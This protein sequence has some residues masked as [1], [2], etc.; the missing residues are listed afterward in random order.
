M[1]YRGA[2]EYLFSLGRFGIK[3]GLERIRALL[4]ELGNPHEGLAAIHVAGTNG[5]GSVCAMLESILSSQGYRVGL[6]T[7][8][9]LL[10]IRERIRV[11]GQFVP[12]DFVADWTTG[13]LALGQ[14]AGELTFFEAMTAMA[15]SFFRESGVDIAVLE[16]GLGGRWDATNVAQARIAVITDISMDHSEH[17]GNSLAQIAG[18]KAGII[19]PGSHVVTHQDSA[20]ALSVIVRACEERQAMLVRLNS[21]NI[22]PAGDGRPDVMRL[23][24][25]HGSHEIKVPLQGRHQMTNAALAV[26][27][28]E[29]AKECY[30]LPVHAKHIARGVAASLWPARFQVF[31]N[32]RQKTVIDSAHNP[33]GIDTLLAT[34]R[35]LYPG[36]RRPALFVMAFSKDKDYLRMLAPVLKT[37]ANVLLTA[38]PNPRSLYPETGLE[39]IRAAFP[40][41]A[42]ERL[43]SAASPEQ[44]LGHPFYRPAELICVAGSLFLAGE[45][46]RLIAEGKV[47]GRFEKAHSKMVKWLEQASTEFNYPEC[48]A[49][50]R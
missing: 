31:A 19:K 6:Y 27:A 35:E 36:R 49:P 40:D 8:P 12:E 46:L 26:M 42:P 16:T 28:A 39:Q 34:L 29:N 48:R 13:L 9:H 21:E 23:E 10:T 14:A 3:P 25:A 24:T 44:A 22:A 4:G 32:H 43:S 15:F 1:D 11:G 41:V 38:T 5:K 30:D 18:E 17:L 2:R 37:G 7:S 50:I 45:W 20:A 47:R 33:A